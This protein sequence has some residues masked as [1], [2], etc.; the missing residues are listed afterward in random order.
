MS[1]Q[2]LHF[3]AEV[4]R[5]LEIV[6]R[7]LYSEKEVFL[8]E[9]VSNASDA[10]D[11][12]RYAALTN[13]D[14]VEGDAEYQVRLSVDKD[15]RT[16]TVAD[17]GIGMSRDELI[18][19]LGTIARSGTLAA[20]EALTGDAKKDMQLI[21][22]FGVGFYSSFVVADS[23]E[24]ISR[25]AGESEAWRWVSDGKG[26]FTIGEAGEQPRGTT[27]ILHLAGGEDEFLDETRLRSVI[28]THS[29]HVWLPIVMKIGEADETLNRASALWTRPKSEISDDDYKEFY[30]HV[31]HAFDEPWLTVH[32]RAEGMIEYTALL[33]VPT[34]QPFDLFLPERKHHL[35]LYVRRVFITDEAEGLVP[36]WLRFLRGV[37]DSEDLPLNVSREMLQSSPMITKIRSGLTKRVLQE[38]EKRA[39]DTAAYAIFWKA[40]GAVVKEGVYEDNEHRD[41]LLPLMRLRST[42]T[43][44][45]TSLDAYVERMKDGQEA[46]YYLTG[47]DLEA[48]ARSP[49]LEGFRAKGVEVL[50]LSDP[51]DEFWVSAVGTFKDKEL[52]SITRAGA[53]LAA[54]HAPQSKEKTED[55]PEP[56]AAIDQLLAAFKDVLK[57]EVKDVRRSERL[58]DSP[59]CLVADEHDM[60]IHMER[61]LRQHR[62][63][64]V[65]AKRIL[66]INPTH[67]LVVSLCGLVGA[68]EGGV[69]DSRLDD[70]A[71]LLLD[72]ARIIEGEPL[73]DPVAFSR[74]LSEAMRRGINVAA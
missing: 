13:P 65:Q 10:C 39:E 8:R 32:Y 12:L 22:Q 7:S 35:K 4:S 9:L 14:L 48:M 59:V 38:L 53:D 72:Q 63:L 51:V 11:R 43:D 49:H 24:V 2:R 5:L 66:E 62:Q 47:D 33:F 27:V 50:L 69:R 56:P 46:I 21:G 31:G 23:V 45:L 41:T 55:Q 6:A 29:D 34:G 74:R 1:E 36:S 28:K 54:I 70:L 57:D 44:E 42:N 60:D 3:Q 67:P 19:N 16:L 73:P 71:L 40:F 26:D 58:T 68:G 37:V 52:K 20:L 61:M 64:A 25:R 17:N 15:A 18:E 30:H